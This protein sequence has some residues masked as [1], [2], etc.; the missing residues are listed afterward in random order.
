MQFSNLVSV[1]KNFFKRNKEKRLQIFL[2]E[3]LK[4]RTASL[5]CFCIQT[6][7]SVVHIS[8]DTLTNIH[9]I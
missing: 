8:L 9:S 1:E 5:L 4:C 2:R 7:R 3:Y 6:L